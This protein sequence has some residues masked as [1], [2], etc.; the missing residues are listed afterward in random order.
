MR[1]EVQSNWVRPEYGDPLYVDDGL[2]RSSMFG[3]HA[4]VQVWPKSAPFCDHV[5]DKAGKV[6]FGGYVKPQTVPTLA[7]PGA[8]MLWNVGEPFSVRSVSKVPLASDGLVWP[9]PGHT[10]ANLKDLELELHARGDFAGS[11]LK[12]VD[13]QNVRVKVYLDGTAS[14]FVRMAGMVDFERSPG[15]TLEVFTGTCLSTTV[16]RSIGSPGLDAVVH[17][18]VTAY[19]GALDTGH[20]Y[21]TKRHKVDGETRW[22]EGGGRFDWRGRRRL[23]SL[24]D[25][26]YKLR[27]PFGFADWMGDDWYD[28]CEVYAKTAYVSGPGN[29]VA[30]NRITLDTR[31]GWK[32]WPDCPTRHTKNNVLS[33]LV[34]V[35]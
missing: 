2:L 6:L 30:A 34:V 1:K 33:G 15:C 14:D 5:L 25:C 31:H 17:S 16:V 29:N 24:Y 10:V 27:P 9:T 13:S 19:V 28:G 4:Y 7:M 20:G 11:L 23:D 35:R 8:P 32:E 26:L 3:K 18:G 22:S 21:Y 12:V